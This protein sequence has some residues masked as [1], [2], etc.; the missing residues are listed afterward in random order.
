MSESLSA[1]CEIHNPTFV[2]SETLGCS[3]NGRRYWLEIHKLQHLHWIVSW[4]RSVTLGSYDALSCI[5][6]APL[7]LVYVGI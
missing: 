5:G 1:V 4:Q 6:S 2:E 3:S 7:L